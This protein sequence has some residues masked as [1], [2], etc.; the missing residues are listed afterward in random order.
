MLDR[1][2]RALTQ[3]GK[4]SEAVRCCTARQSNLL[5]ILIEEIHQP[6]GCLD[7]S[8][9]RLLDPIEEEVH[10]GLPITGGPDP[11]QMSV[12]DRAVL[13]QI[14]GEIKQGLGEQSPM[15]KK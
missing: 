2:S 13:L 12:V 6:P 4:N 8:I 15:M 11:L 1:E 9:R 5:L 7:C 10:P 14:E 3:G